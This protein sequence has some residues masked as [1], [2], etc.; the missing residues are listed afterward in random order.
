VLY[1]VLW[2]PGLIANIVFLREANAVQRETGVAPAGRG[3]LIAQLAIVGAFFGIVGLLFI[4]IAA[5]GN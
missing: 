3:C 2:V 1:C 4:V 5:T